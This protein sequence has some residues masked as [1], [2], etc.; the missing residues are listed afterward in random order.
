MKKKL[1]L[2]ISLLALT[3]SV[4][5]ASDAISDT[6]LFNDI[7][8]SYKNGYYPGTIDKISQLQN[9]FPDSAY[10]QEALLYKGISYFYI[11]R[12]EASVEALKKSIE[13]M[14]NNSSDRLEAL[15]ALGRSLYYNNEYES[16]TDFLYQCCELSVKRNNFTFY[17]P[18]I[19]FSGRAFFKLEEY[20]KAIPLF[21]YV[22]E[23][24]NYYSASDYNEVLQKLMI[25]YD[26]CGKNEK[27]NELYVE[28]DKSS[29]SEDLY[30]IITLYNADACAKLGRNKIAYDYYCRII[31]CGNEQLAIQALKKAYVLS[32]ETNIGVNPGEVFEKSADTFY[33]NPELVEEFWIR[34]GIDEFIKK[35]YSKAEEYFS[36]ANSENLLIL[37]YKAKILLDS[38]KDAKSAENLLLEIQDSVAE[39][40]IENFQDSYYSVLLQC[41]YLQKKWSEIPETFEKISN[42]DHQSV[43]VISAYYYN[44][45]EY[46]NVDS[47]CGELYASALCKLGAYDKACK[48]YAN[49]GIYNSDYA[50]AL[51]A[52]GRYEDSY[53]VAQKS[54]DTQKEYVS[55]I[56]QIN[57][58]NWELAKN[59]FSNYIKQMSGK[60]DFNTFS[61]FYKGYAEYCLEEYKN[62]YASFVRYGV[63]TGSSTGK[64]LYLRQGYEYAAKSAL[65]NGDLKNAAIQAENVIKVSEPGEEKQKAVVF[66]AEVLSDSK[67]YEKAISTLAPYI[68]GKDNFA[69][70]TMFLTAD[71]YN[72]KGDVKQAD[73]YFNKVYTDHPGTEFSE[74]ALFRCG[75]VFYAHEDYGT[76]LNRFTTYIYKY[77]NGKFSA[78]ALFFGGDCALR[79]GENDRAIMLTN[80]M[81]QKYQSSI[82]TYGANKNLLTA[83]SNIENYGQALQVA[84][85]LVKEYQKEAADDEIGKKLI[86]LEKLVNGVDKRIVD[87]QSEYEKQK[88][89]S[90]KAGRIA[91]TQ[92]VQLY[93]ASSY[94]QKEAYDLAVEL[95]A[96]QTAGDERAYAAINAEFIADYNRKN[97]ENR[98][99]AQ[100]YLKAAEYYRNVD[101][102]DKAAVVLYGAVEAFVADGYEG[103]GRE[104]A[105]LLKSLYPDSRQAQRVDRL[106]N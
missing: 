95:L 85:F 93:A 44:K 77:A 41:K 99:A 35:N 79:L 84:K 43:Y 75:E 55:G 78:P 105:E 58:K 49:L 4:F 1:L 18:S 36:K 27:I 28:I 15:F 56:C 25:S 104:T 72:K 82:Y 2:L 17:N 87:K 96:K 53:S 57:L 73:Y 98:Q 81:L 67:D 50:S 97:N 86:Q 62:S 70:E 12:Y 59:H 76:A 3:F 30:N 74:E 6:V 14:D 66:C 8:L 69:A 37:L 38:K 13:M 19:L 22:I 106:F 90:T 26:N 88:G 102:S 23:N 83:Y 24:G 10:I 5:C 52:C 42:P 103:D 7:K 47:S 71:M 33:K 29:I 91:G 65:Q 60:S 54:T 89:S 31:E 20:E 16:A 45:G 34:L 92:L 68:N 61:F 40:K 11:K 48:I 94:T 46:K 101:D 63:E 32:L 64:K 51:F 21:E 100:M 9:N 39:S 80:T